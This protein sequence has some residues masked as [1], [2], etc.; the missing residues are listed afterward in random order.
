M[1]CGLPAG[2][3]LVSLLASNAGDA[4]DWRT[5][6]LI[7]GALPLLLVPVVLWLLPETRP[8]HDPDADRGL[9]RGLFQSAGRSPPS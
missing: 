4:L 3:A 6:F 1:F 9:A 2:G 8:D 7:G 5:I